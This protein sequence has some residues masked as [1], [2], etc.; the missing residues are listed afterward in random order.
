MQFSIE[1]QR[2]WS[3]RD[4]FQSSHSIGYF[5]ASVFFV[6]ELEILLL[7]IGLRRSVADVCTR[8]GVEVIHMQGSANSPSNIMTIR[9]KKP[10]VLIS[11]AGSQIFKKYLMDIPSICCLNLH[12][13]ALPRFRGLMPVFWAMLHGEKEIGVTIFEMDE[14]IDTGPI[15]KQ[16][17]V[18]VMG[19]SLTEMIK[20]T[21]FVGMQ[22]IHEV[23]TDL[24]GGE[25]EKYDNDD[26]LATYHSFPNKSDVQIFKA[27]GNRLV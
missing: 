8:Y 22:L 19:R 23:L 9:E 1:S 11:I 15:V 24:A 27:N 16:V 10:E 17:Y 13:G 2:K 21:K 12:N 5:W 4:V 20:L 7:R 6:F 26:S 25:I 3:K 18:P 14:G